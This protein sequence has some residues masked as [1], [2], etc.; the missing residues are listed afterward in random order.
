MFASKPR[1]VPMPYKINR[2]AEQRFTIVCKLGHAV[3]Q[4]HNFLC[5]SD[6]VFLGY[7]FI[8]LRK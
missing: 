5:D 1:E 8:S 2:Q 4:T 6:M 7:L 3:S